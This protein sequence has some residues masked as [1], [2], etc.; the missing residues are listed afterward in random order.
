MACGCGCKGA[1]GGCGGG[2]GGPEPTGPVLLPLALGS[3]GGFGGLGSLT[4]AQIDYRN[5]LLRRAARGGAEERA[6][7]Q[8]WGVRL[9]LDGWLRYRADPGD[10]RIN[11]EALGLNCGALAIGEFLGG[12]QAHGVNPVSPL[13]AN[14]PT[15][16]LALAGPLVF[17]GADD[18]RTGGAYGVEDTVWVVASG[19]G[20]VVPVSA[21]QAY[22]DPTKAVAHMTYEQY[23]E[24]LNAILAGGQPVAISATTQV[25]PAGFTASGPDGGYAV[26]VTQAPEGDGVAVVAETGGVVPTT[27]AAPAQ[28]E[29]GSNNAIITWVKAN[30]MPALLLGGLVVIA[31]TSKGGRW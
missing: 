3:S 13:L 21:T 28:V 15:V 23:G 7:V 18:G 4:M 29:S 20:T 12:L 14:T 17:Q 8:D 9:D 25:A 26:G 16:D 2:G 22:E 11:C 19:T 24:L 5:Q 27:V 10:V 6:V 30:P 1:P 31:L